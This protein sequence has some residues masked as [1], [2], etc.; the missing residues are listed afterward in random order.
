MRILIANPFGIGDILFTRPLVC[1]LRQIFPKAWMV[2]LCNRRVASLL[3]CWPELNR[4]EVFE[5]DEFR[6]AWQQSRVMAIRS[7]RRW[8]GRLRSERFDI[9][10]DLSLSWQYGLAGWLCGIPKRVGFNHKGRG[11]FLTHTL[12]LEGFHERPVADHILDLLPLMGLERLRLDDE[13]LLLPA[14]P[15]PQLESQLKHLGILGSPI[16]SVGLVPGGGISWG[17]WARYKQWPP[18]R[19]IELARQIQA[20]WGAR[21]VLL[22]DQ[23][24]E[25]LCREIGAHLEGPSAWM[26]PAPSL[27]LMAEVFRRCRLVI[28]ND[29]GPIHLAEMVGTPTVSI[30]GPVDPGVYGPLVQRAIHRV[31]VKGLA[32]RPCYR[33]FRFPPCP[34]DNA[35]LRQLPVER[36][37]E[38]VESIWDSHRS[39]VEIS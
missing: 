19:F 23:S 31:V 6:M 2:F 13:A 29:S 26:A 15:L 37:M 36:V 20:R 39:C 25:P 5:K 38:A 21:I 22:G 28:G 3:T 17:P 9:L 7:L 24:E 12:P 32:C 34:W 4:V 11:R 14:H 8:I 16:P 18:D 10:I 1:A 33:A 35:C 30:F 27:A